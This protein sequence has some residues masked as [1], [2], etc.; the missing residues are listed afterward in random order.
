MIWVNHEH[1]LRITC[2]YAVAK[3]HFRSVQTH[4]TVLIY[5]L[6]CSACDLFGMV[7]GTGSEEVWGATVAA[8][9]RLSSQ[10]K[11]AERGALSTMQVS[12]GGCLSDHGSHG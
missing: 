9:S 2:S 4:I 5:T 10:A 12:Q 6:S 3:E 11:N 1:R 7:L 8:F